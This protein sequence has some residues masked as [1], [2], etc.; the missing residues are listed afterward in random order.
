MPVIELDAFAKVAYDAYS[1]HMATAR[2]LL[3]PKN[4]MPIPSWEEQHPEIQECWRTA[5]T[6]V[7]EKLD[8]P[9]PRVQCG[10]SIQVKRSDGMLI[11]T[12][13]SLPPGHET[14]CGA[15]IEVP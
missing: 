9:G 2:T 12:V 1:A 4:A 3:R 11:D 6:A 7:I 15:F 14:N 5:V 10:L 13:C 8:E